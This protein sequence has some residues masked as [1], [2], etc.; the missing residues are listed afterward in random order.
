MTGLG[1]EVEAIEG[2]M[3]DGRTSVLHLLH[4]CAVRIFYLLGVSD[5]HLQHGET[6]G[7][8]SSQFLCS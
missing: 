8:S 3:A 2:A 7:A 5:V 4:H 6:C 1:K